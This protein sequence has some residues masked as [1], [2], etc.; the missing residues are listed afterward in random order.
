MPFFED[1]SATA[2]TET[3]SSVTEGHDSISGGSHLDEKLSV[4]FDWKPSSPEKSPACESSKLD[5]KAKQP[6]ILNPVTQQ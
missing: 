3:F 4:L 2:K 1:S 5:E 6:V